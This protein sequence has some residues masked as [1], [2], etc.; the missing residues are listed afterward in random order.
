M[1]T[2][3]IGQDTE[4]TPE[5]VFD[6]LNKQINI[7]FKKRDLNNAKISIHSL[8]S[9]VAI[10]WRD[11]SSQYSLVTYNKAIYAYFKG[12]LTE[13]MEWFE[14]TMKL[15]KKLFG[16]KDEY[17][18]KSIA[19][20]GN[21]YF[22]KGDFKTALKVYK[23]GLELNKEIYHQEGIHLAKD[24]NN[25]AIAYKELG[26][27]EQAEE[28]LLE[29][30]RL[31]IKYDS[32]DFISIS[33]SYQNL[34]LLYRAIGNVEKDEEY[35][36]KA[37]NGFV[38]F[39]ELS[40]H[41]EYLN[42][43]CN[44]GEFYNRMDKYKDAQGFLLKSEEVLERY[45]SLKESMYFEAYLS[46]KIQL[47]NSLGNYAKSKEIQ[48]NLLSFVG[49]RYGKKHRRHAL[50]LMI[51]G[52]N[53]FIHNDYE[54]CK[55]K[56]S[57]AL[58][59]LDSIEGKNSI[60][61]I[62]CLTG[63]SNSAW[64]TEKFSEMLTLAIEAQ[65]R[66]ETNKHV[67]DSITY[68]YIIYLLGEA[69]SNLHQT[70]LAEEYF[71][72]SLHWRARVFG[73]ENEDYLTSL[74]GLSAHYLR[75]GDEH[76]G[77]YYLIESSKVVRTILEKSKG[78]MTQEELSNYVAKFENIYHQLLTLCSLSKD[79]NA[80]AIAFENALFYK[81]FI[82]EQLIAFNNE[83]KTNFQLKNE[84]YLLRSTEERLSKLYKNIQDEDDKNL[85]AQLENK[86]F[87]LEKKIL[88]FTKYQP[89]TL[90][91]NWK[92]TQQRL[93]E[94]SAM[95]K[96]VHYKYNNGNLSD[97][98]L[99][100]AFLLKKNSDYPLFIPL[101]DQRQLDKIIGK[102][103]TKRLEYVNH[104]YYSSKSST[105]GTTESMYDLVWKNIE[106]HLKEVKK[107]HYS[108]SGLLH[109]INIQYLIT[110]E[111][112]YISDMYDLVLHSSLNSQVKSLSAAPIVFEEGVVLFGGID[113][114]AN[115][116]DQVET[117]AQ[118]E[119]GKNDLSSRGK[120]QWNRAD[121]NYYH[122]KWNYLP[123]SHK[124]VKIIS[125]FCKNTNIINSIYTG[126]EA[127]E[128]KFKSL[129]RYTSTSTSPS[130]IHLST[131]GFF[132]SDLD[133]KYLAQYYTNKSKLYSNPM[134]RS[135]LLLAGA[136]KNWS[137]SMAILNPAE[138]GVLTADEISLMDLSSTKLIVLSACETGLGEI[139]S[140]E[141]VYGLQ[142]AF[143]IAGV[144]SIIMSLWQV[145]DKQTA[146]LMELFYKNYLI[147]KMN[148][149][150]SLL[151]AQKTLRDKKLEPYYWAS[152]ILL[153]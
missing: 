102:H 115:S 39:P 27:Y 120:Q 131:H 99:Y 50:S 113:Y 48:E 40:S 32:S 8:D 17:Y 80:H 109:N 135:G 46:F 118:L 79:P 93:K 126:K 98:V 71:L 136:N 31:K 16:E 13:S 139:Q 81:G 6:T 152:F 35:N 84:Y 15:R 21:I 75:N 62:I 101:C 57:E 143:K 36:L 82:K 74:Q 142:R 53:S 97:S 148:I 23:K 133:S 11:S 140:N 107:I 44:T 24:L 150:D 12:S 94:S 138:D 108:V 132:F 18:Y 117:I 14:S 112:K 28:N 7:C 63:L 122:K 77:L 26:Y 111:K 61:T 83:L 59:I 96:F 116:T 54:P 105:N 149:R 124:E 41:P 141:G 103:R 20:S 100:A 119:D 89:D 52:N 104:I 34:A 110:P 69:Y 49:K 88:S 134:L 3:L 151:T 2:L 66:I 42:M 137:D 9:L 121:S 70:A 76:Q 68:S 90:N 56:Y 72:K 1:E 92:N 144:Q 30:I 25:V 60:N 95:L 45:P 4:L 64:K 147:N 51:A 86:K 153:E 10:H 37:L 130:I 38:R 5:K 33:Q 127:S 43:L 91:A 129:G 22:V 78:F 65:T 29:A 146:E 106:P 145:P 123:Y 125:E 58:E 55:E 67:L 47:N 87:Q 85:I 73:T 114:N 19:N 128:D